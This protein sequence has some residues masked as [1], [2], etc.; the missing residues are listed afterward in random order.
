MEGKQKKAKGRSRGDGGTGG[1]DGEGGEDQKEDSGL[2]LG[3][4]FKSFSYC[5]T[6]S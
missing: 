4:E 5:V 2:Q 3:A 1:G 6:R